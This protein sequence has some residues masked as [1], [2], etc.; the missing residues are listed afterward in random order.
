LR[1][2]EGIIALPQGDEPIYFLGKATAQFG[3]ARPTDALATLDRLQSQWPAFRSQEGH[4]LYAMALEA[5]ERPQEALREYEALVN[6]LCRRGAARAR[7]RCSTG[8]AA[9]PRQNRSQPKS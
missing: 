3:L 8:W 2:Y 1:L 6:L 9:L 5:A 4:L 7:W